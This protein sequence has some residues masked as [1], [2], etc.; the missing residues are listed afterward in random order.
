MIAFARRRKRTPR[1]VRDLTNLTRSDLDNVA[2]SINTY[3][4]G[5]HP[6]AVRDTLPDFNAAFAL[7]MLEMAARHGRDVSSTIARF[8][9][10]GVVATRPH[11]YQGDRR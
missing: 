4:L 5:G 11:V 10:A 9:Y 8:K 6:V 1:L 3:S 7:E 2:R